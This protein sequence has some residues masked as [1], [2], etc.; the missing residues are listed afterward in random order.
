M[1]GYD[2]SQKAA[3]RETDEVY[4]PIHGLVARVGTTAAEFPLII[5]VWNSMREINLNSSF[6][7]G[8]NALFRFCF[9]FNL[10]Y[11]IYEHRRV[12][13]NPAF[14]NKAVS[15]TICRADAVHLGGVHVISIE[16]IRAFNNLGTRPRTSHEWR[17]S[18]HFVIMQRDL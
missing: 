12:P 1:I 2:K 3:W 16:W 15:L 13:I 18:R 7:F 10:F 5:F 8:V 11:F 6:C 14:P 17:S 9:F 4:S